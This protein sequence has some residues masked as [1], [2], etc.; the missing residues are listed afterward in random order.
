[1]ERAE[2]RLAVGT[3]NAKLINRHFGVV[4]HEPTVKKVHAE[5][6]VPEQTNHCNM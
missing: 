2:L 4:Q 1:M 3:R 5:Q 6:N